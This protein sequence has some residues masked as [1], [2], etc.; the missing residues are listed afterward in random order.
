MTGARGHGGLD[1][2]M[3]RYGGRR[4]DWVDLSTGINPVP[5]PVPLLDPKACTAL[6]GRA[7]HDTLTQA[8][9][10]FWGMPDDAAILAAPGTASLV[11]HVPGL[12]RAGR[13]HIP[14]PVRTRHAKAFAAHGW[15]EGEDSPDARVLVHPDDPTGGWYSSDDLG[16]P[17]T[18]IDESYA[19]VSPYQSLVSFADREGTLILKSLGRFWGLAGLRLG[20]AIGPQDEIDRLSARLGPLSVSG[21]ALA[22]GTR[23]LSDR[24]WAADTRTR[25]NEDAAHL[26]ALMVRAGAGVVGGTSLFRLYRVEDAAAWQDRL[27]QARVWSRSYPDN[28]GWLRLGLPAPG[29]W[30]RVEQAI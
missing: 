18:V 29:N 23:A 24:A 6:P 25:L 12:L 22:I 19:D 20:F 13:V 17:F 28:P 15:T 27:A 11:A 14:A 16:A 5:Y 30:P 7:A 1:T 10:E 2:A 3:A 9:R 21:P 4:E 26:D 8:A